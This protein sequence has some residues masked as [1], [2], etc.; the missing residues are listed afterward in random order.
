[1]YRLRGAILAAA[2]RHLLRVLGLIVLADL[3][4]GGLEPRIDNVAHA[5]GVIAGVGLALIFRW[6]T[7][8]RLAP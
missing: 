8:T 2:R 4:I 1:M 6:P 5:G 7:T 3:V